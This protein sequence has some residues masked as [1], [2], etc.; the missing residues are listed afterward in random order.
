V[1]HTLEF[2]LR[3]GYSLLFLWV[4]A[5]Q[6]ALP[7]PSGPLLLACGALARSG[8][9]SP[10][11]IV[12]MGLLPCLIADSS[13][14]MVGRWRGTRVLRLICRLSLEPDSCVR[15]TETSFLRYGVRSLLVSKF[16]PGLSAVSAPLS[17]I[18][19]V[20]LGKFLLFDA[21][22]S[23]IWLLAYAGAG[24]ILS[25][26]L[27][28]IAD[29]AAR[30]GS[31]VALVVVGLLA[32]W[33]GWKYYQRRRFLKKLTVDRITATELREKL[34]SG[35]PLVIVDVRSVF[36]NDD[37]I[38]GALHIPLEDLDARHADIP[39]DRDIVLFCSCPNEA[40]SARAAL[41]LRKR[42]V[43]RVHPLY[44]GVDAWRALEQAS[45]RASG[46]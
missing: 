25:N 28:L 6:A 24:Y 34:Q 32:A 13:W 46:G 5:E 18:S 39:R 26:Q 9:M 45:S 31:W 36:E 14:F 16:V 4:L 38:P 20:S 19:G 29:Y 8:R 17:A 27:D 37:S 42:G 3:H 30:M 2:V 43:V 21:A 40:S 41:L 35:E 1:T 12:L 33:I 7:I 22:G 44:G 15:Q 11:L 23:L 10:H